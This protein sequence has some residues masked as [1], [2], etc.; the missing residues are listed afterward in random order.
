M[1]IRSNVMVPLRGGDVCF[2]S[3]NFGSFQVGSYGP[4]ELALAQE[5]ADK[6]AVAIINA[7]LHEALRESE[8]RFRSLYEN[9]PVMM[10]SID[11]EGRLVSVNNYWLE[12]LGYER[13]D[14]LGRQSTDFLTEASRR[15]AVEVT[16]PVFLKTGVA[17][18]V[19]YQMVKQSGEVIDVLLSANSNPPSMAWEAHTL[20]FFSRCDR[21]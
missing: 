18:D 10:H 13:A 14:V 5:I 12:T 4:D 16:L 7:K 9:T 1:G 17:R 15:H 8:E 2:G 3:L 11:H 6:V 19:E 20:A 21:G